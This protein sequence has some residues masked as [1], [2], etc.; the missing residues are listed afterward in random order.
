MQPEVCGT[1]LRQLI[2]SFRVYILPSRMAETVL[3]HN[4]A[5]GIENRC[6]LLDFAVM[7][8]TEKRIKRDPLKM[9]EDPPTHMIFELYFMCMFNMINREVTT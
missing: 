5:T 8:E 7:I 2:E 3:P 6:Q 1:C 9:K 4:L